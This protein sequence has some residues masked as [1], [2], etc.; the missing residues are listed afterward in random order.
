MRITFEGQPFCNPNKTGI[1]IYAYNI[2]TNILK[3]DKTNEYYINIFDFLNLHKAK[4]FLKKDSNLNSAII[5]SNGFLPY[6]VFISYQKLFK[7]IP[8]EMFLRNKSDISHFFN[9]AVPRNIS[10]KVITNVYDMVYKRFPETMNKINYQVLN[11]HLS[12]SCQR[13]DMILTI[14]Q[15]SKNE[16]VEYMNVHPD[17]IEIAYSAVDRDIYYNKPDKAYLRSKYNIDSD[18]IF[19]LG[20]LEPRKNV[21]ALIKAFKIISG[22]YKDIKLVIA[23]GE[24]WKSDNVFELIEDLKLLHKV[25]FLGYVSK[26]DKPILYSS[27]SMFVFPSLYEGFGIP[28][29]E[30]MACGTPVVVADNSSLPEVVQ[31]AGILVDSSDIESLAFQMERLLNDSQLRSRYIEKGLLQSQKFSWADSA[32]KVMKIYNTLK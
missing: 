21:A 4:D 1:G 24:G 7:F 6:R 31:D 28:P 2:V 18:Y 32:Q 29:L 27:A 26:E 5:K 20:T 12:Y 16:I 22:K 14:S 17:K 23:G 3:L 10:G 30:A 11:R 25:L 9:F 15:N 8:Y 19:Y 13:A